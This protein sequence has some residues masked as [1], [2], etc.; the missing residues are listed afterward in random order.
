MT[1]PHPSVFFTAPA[2]TLCGEMM[3]GVN[4]VLLVLVDTYLYNTYTSSHTFIYT[5]LSMEIY[6]QTD[7]QIA[8]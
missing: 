1:C 2:K 3:R 7:R 5:Y 8:R 6:R 4:G